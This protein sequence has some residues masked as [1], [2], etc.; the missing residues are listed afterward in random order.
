MSGCSCSLS[1]WR[2]LQNAART[3]RR[4][5]SS[6]SPRGVAR[7]AVPG[8]ARRGIFRAP[9]PATTRLRPGANALVRRPS[10][11]L[12]VEGEGWGEGGCF[13]EAARPKSSTVRQR[14]RSSPSPRGVARSAVPGRARRGIFRATNQPATRLE[15]ARTPRIGTG[16]NPSPGGE[17]WSLPRTRSGGEGSSGRGR[18]PSKRV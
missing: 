17:G 15:Q 2:P 6:P 16:L 9:S 1:R 5:D 11:S 10:F 7:S 18:H 8:R 14:R 13:G 3:R 12:A 4:A